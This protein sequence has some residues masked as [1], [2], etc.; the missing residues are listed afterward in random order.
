MSSTTSNEYVV[1]ECEELDITGNPKGS[2]RGNN[3]EDIALMDDITDFVSSGGLYD[4]IGFQSMLGII[5]M[6]I[7]YYIGDYIFIQYPKSLMVGKVSKF[8]RF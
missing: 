6:M 7:I 4:N 1:N 2:N 5:I 3:I 8:D